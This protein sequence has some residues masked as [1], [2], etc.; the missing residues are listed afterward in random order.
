MG[1]Y[2]GPRERQRLDNVIH[3]L[4]F[5]ATRAESPVRAKTIEEQMIVEF[6]SRV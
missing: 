2:T 1:R 5:A 6:Y 3:R 4:G